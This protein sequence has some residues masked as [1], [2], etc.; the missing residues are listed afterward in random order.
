MNTFFSNM[1]INDVLQMIGTGVIL[2]VLLL[3][4]WNSANQEKKE[5]MHRVEKRED[6]ILLVSKER[7][8]RLM[9]YLET[10]N[11]TDKEIVLALQKI[12]DRVQNIEKII[13]ITA[14]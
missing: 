10:K 5:L 2:P 13:E 4:F 11:E 8:Q 7:E 3:Y 12:V 6:E 14:K 9:D 1:N